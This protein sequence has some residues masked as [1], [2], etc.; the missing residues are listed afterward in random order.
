MKIE[1]RANRYLGKEETDEKTWKDF[2]A[3]SETERVAKAYETGMRDAFMV[4]HRYL[5]LDPLE[6]IN[7]EG[8]YMIIAKELE[9]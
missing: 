7:K 1:E 6:S 2:R 8:L 5:K 9:D 3:Q 4:I